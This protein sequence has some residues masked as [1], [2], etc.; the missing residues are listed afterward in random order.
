MSFPDPSDEDLMTRVQRDDRVA[1]ERLYARWAPRTFGFLFKRD[2]SRSAAEEANQEAWL[3]VYKH[4]RRFDPRRGSFRR[5]LFTL[6]ANS[7]ETRRRRSRDLPLDEPEAVRV[8]GFEAASLARDA[9]LRALGALEPQDRALFLLVLE[10]FSAAD[11]ARAL[12]IN[13]NTARVRLH[14]ARARL[15]EL[16]DD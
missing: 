2:L 6:V 8:E 14:R 4:R 12:D 15:R 7:G 1:Y 5:W 3:K 9:V 13:P 10:G 11:A 16:L